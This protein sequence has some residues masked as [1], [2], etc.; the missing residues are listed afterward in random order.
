VRDTLLLWLALSIAALAV[1]CGGDLAS[2]E[3]V[4]PMAEASEPLELGTLVFQDA[5]LRIQADGRFTLLDAEGAVV[6]ERVTFGELQ[7]LAPEVAIHYRAMTAHPTL[8]ASLTPELE[9][10]DLP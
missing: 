4:D 9:P 2:T 10:G 6:A 8:D 7:E 5:Q 3:P 1:A